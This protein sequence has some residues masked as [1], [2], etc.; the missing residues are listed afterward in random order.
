MRWAVLVAPLALVGCISAKPGAESV[1]LLANAEL[2]KG[3]AF[4]EQDSIGIDAL[5]SGG[6][7]NLRKDLITKMKN[8]AVS[9]GG[10]HVLTSGPTVSLPGPVT[11]ITGDIYRCG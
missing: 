11:N 5:E 8:K 6:I 9:V 3:C 2:V 10:T 4:I 1:Q 7:D